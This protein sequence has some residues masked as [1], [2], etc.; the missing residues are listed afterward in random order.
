MFVVNLLS[1]VAHCILKGNEKPKRV[2]KA[3][4]LSEL[5][6]NVSRLSNSI[7]NSTAFVFSLCFVF[8]LIVEK[9]ER[10]TDRS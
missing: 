5:C 1:T 2:L 7:S 8:Y 4:L 9:R 6:S 3:L 10:L